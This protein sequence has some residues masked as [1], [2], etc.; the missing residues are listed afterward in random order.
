MDNELVLEKEGGEIHRCIHLAQ[1]S[2]LKNN[3]KDKSYII[4]NNKKVNRYNPDTGKLF[5]H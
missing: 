2:V 3:H 5:K 1:K 4:Y